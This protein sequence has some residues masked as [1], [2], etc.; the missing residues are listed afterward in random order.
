MFKNLN[1]NREEI[2]PSIRRY[3][4]GRYENFGVKV[5]KYP[6][7]VRYS[8]T[9]IEERSRDIF[10]DCYLVKNGTTTINVSNGQELEEKA[11]IAT[12]IKNDKK[13]CIESKE[14]KNKSV[15][16]NNIDSKLFNTIIENIKDEYQDYISESY[17]VQENDSM[18]KCSGKNSDSITVTHFA[19]TN[20]VRMQGKPL[21]MFS[22]AASFFEQIIPIEN[23]VES[24]EVNY[25]KKI[26]I[27]EIDKQFKNYLPNSY[28]KHSDSLKKSLLKSVYNLNI[29]SFEYTCTELCFEALRALEGHLKIILAQNNVYVEY[30]FNMFQYN[31]EFDK[32]YLNA[33][34]KK[35]INNETKVE[36]FEEVY[37]YIKVF[38]HKIFHWDS[39]NDLGVDE[40]IHYEDLGEVKNIIVD[41]LTLIDKYYSI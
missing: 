6:S 30:R 25:K 26:E 40:T 33:C 32:A 19:G 13:C 22:I 4:E 23:F 16:F 17:F 37:N 21:I 2:E 10:L 9:V 28:N 24:I 15:I 8:L 27:G 11:K 14:V 35:L 20:N 39:P 36:Y 29:I 7:F 18:W 5:D 12:F 31:K 3:A 38:R 34:T 41:S 1:L